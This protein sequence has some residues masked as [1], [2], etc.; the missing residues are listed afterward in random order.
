MLT[1]RALLRLISGGPRHTKAKKLQI[2]EV[3]AVLCNR[4]Q[5]CGIAMEMLLW[6]R[7]AI[8]YAGAFILNL[9]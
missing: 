9:L 1:E 7:G 2:A 4:Q 3:R 5:R 6:R 8:N